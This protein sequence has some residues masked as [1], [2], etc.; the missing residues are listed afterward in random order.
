MRRRGFTLMEMLFSMMITALVALAAS[1]I[2]ITVAQDF[3]QADV[4][5]SVDLQATLMTARLESI[6]RQCKEI[7]L[8]RAGS[9]DGSASQPAAIMLWMNDNTM[10]TGSMQLSEIGLI[11]H[12]PTTSHVY[13]YRAVFPSNMT[14]LQIALVNLTYAYS[15]ICVSTA[16]EDF[17][18]LP[19]V[20]A[21]PIADNVT[22]FRVDAQNVATWPQKPTVDFAMTVFVAGKKDNNGTQQTPNKTACQ[23]G[24][25]TLRAPNQ[26]S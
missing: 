12:D 15:S 23:Y 11:Q 1:A 26:P 18:A 17:K 7:G 6:L 3:D 5:Q 21:Q 14:A 19:Y 2:C 20:T 9:L 8:V 10:P 22:G 24:S 25:V 13:L 4:T 16:P